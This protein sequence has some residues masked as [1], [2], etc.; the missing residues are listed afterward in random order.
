MQ[1]RTFGNT[2]IKISA[3][4][5]GT[6]RLPLTEGG[7]AV[8]EKTAIA[9]IRHAID[10]GVNY[11]DTAYMYH[12]GTSEVILGKALADG[13]RDK[14][15]IADKSPMM[16]V[17][18]ESDFDRILDEQLKKLNTDHIDFYLFHCLNKDRFEN[19]V[20]PFHLIDHMLEA[21]KAGKIRHIG[22]SF[23]DDID[24][25]KKIVDYTD[26][27][28]MCQ[29]QY[30]YVNID[31]QAGDEGLH[32][33]ADKGLGVVVMEPL[34]G[35]R[36][37]NISEH[38]AKAFSPDKSVVEHALDFVWN[39]KDVSLLL[40][41]M[42]SYKQVEDNLEYAGRSSIGM[43]S[44]AE[45]VQYRNAKEIYDK[46]SMVNCTACGYCMPCPFGLDIPAIFKAYNNY[47][48]YGIEKAREEYGK[49]E[50]NADDCHQC[51]HCESLCS[52]NIQISKVMQN[53]TKLIG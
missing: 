22:F 25:F 15:F 32:Y 53:I 35:G 28:D 52:Q 30:N 45:L 41:G 1:Y 39:Q 34:M 43:L 7:D 50:L 6:M 11:V 49:L 23:H 40:S 44:E 51:H 29:I 42:G 10:E 9:M 36:L 20:K 46:M 31:Y 16:N 33:A 4:G 38:V 27:W 21:K 24:T 48:L 3:L 26:V 18:E 12:N 8:D 47:G 13:Y 17:N 37:A 5:F 14:V 2:G 19:K